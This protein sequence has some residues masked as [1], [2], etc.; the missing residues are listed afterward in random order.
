LGEQRVAVRQRPVG[1]PKLARA[2]LKARESFAKI[3]NAGTAKTP[4]AK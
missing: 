3:A 2:G 4:S 1:P